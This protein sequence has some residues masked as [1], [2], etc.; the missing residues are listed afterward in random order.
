MSAL[1]GMVWFVLRSVE[2]NSH[3]MDGG[4]SDGCVVACLEFIAIGFQ[5]HT[6]YLFILRSAEA[7]LHEMD[8]GY[9]D[10]FIAPCL[11]FI[12]IGFNQGRT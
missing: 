2:A 1:L 11:V 9:R 7:D 8:V 4:Y 12:A 6:L 10:C 5:G 3:E